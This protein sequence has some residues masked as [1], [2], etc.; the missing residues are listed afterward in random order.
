MTG[1][2]VARWLRAIWNAA[3][4]AFGAIVG[5]AIFAVM[6]FLSAYVIGPAFSGYGADPP[7]GD[8]PSPPTEHSDH[9]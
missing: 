9:H 3:L 5:L 4:G 8:Q 7:S 2:P 1:G 6:F